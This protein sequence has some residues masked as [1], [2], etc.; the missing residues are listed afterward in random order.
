MVGIEA[1][2]NKTDAWGITVPVFEKFGLG[3]VSA[4]DVDLSAISDEP[5][6]VN[7]SLSSALLARIDAIVD[8]NRALYKDRSYF[9]SVAA[10]RE[11]QQ[12]RQA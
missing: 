11:I 12:L 8:T 1:P 9:L 2:K 7:I 10:S 5:K 3:C 4:V 6:R